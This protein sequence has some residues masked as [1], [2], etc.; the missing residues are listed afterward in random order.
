VIFPNLRC[1]GARPGPQSSLRLPTLLKLLRV[2][3]RWRHDQPK[4]PPEIG[5]LDVFGTRTGCNTDPVME[6]ST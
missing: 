4:P 3:S 2:L 5:N 6:A 1:P